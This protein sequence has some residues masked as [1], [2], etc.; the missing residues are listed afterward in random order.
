MRTLFTFSLLVLALCVGC[1][2]TFPEPTKANIAT[3]ETSEASEDT[4]DPNA[5]E[6]LVDPIIRRPRPPAE[7]IPSEKQSEETSGV[8]STILGKYAAQVLPPPVVPLPPVEDLT[9]QID[10]YIKKMGESLEFLDGSPRYEAD[11]SDI[12]R[13]A[14]ALALI[15]LAVGLAEDDSKYK[16]SASLIIETAKNLAAAKTLDEGQKAHAA[17]KASLTVLGRNPL[18]WSDKVAGLT[19]AMKALPNLSSAVKR[20]TDTERKLNVTLGRPTQ[21]IFGQTAAMAAIAQGAI[22]NVVETTKPDAVEEWKK[23]CEEFRDAA[24]KVNA[25]TRQYAKDLADD[26]DPDYSVFNNAYK[27]MVSSCDDCHRVFYPQAVGKE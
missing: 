1:P 4:L 23:L 10:E 13:D 12:V 2:Q 11:A 20:V 8:L 17:L 9:A 26:K 25:V 5:H 18:S 3:P 19:P 15:A 6:Y 7:P 24:I 14:N 27:A 22:P 21:L 16:K